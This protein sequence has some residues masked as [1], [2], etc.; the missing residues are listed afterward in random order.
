MA[1]HRMAV[2]MGL[3]L[4]VSAC[5]THGGDDASAAFDAASVQGAT[6]ELVS[7]A[8]APVLPAANKPTLTFPEPGRVAGSASCNRYSGAARIT[9]EGKLALGAANAL[10]VT[11]MACAEQALNVQ[12]MQFLQLLGAAGQMRLE[13][14]RLSIQSGEQADA[15]VFQRKDGD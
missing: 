5:T 11:R 12:E 10:A 1:T 8:G 9:A 4:L 2:M 6:W 13:G 3:G 7:L 15:L 14:D